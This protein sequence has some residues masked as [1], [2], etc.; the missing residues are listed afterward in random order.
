MCNRSAH[1]GRGRGPAG[2]GRRDL[3][4]AAAVRWSNG[5][6]PMPGRPARTGSVNGVRRVPTAGGGRAPDDDPRPAL[7]GAGPAGRAT[8]LTARFLARHRFTPEQAGVT[9]VAR[10]GRNGATA[11]IGQHAIVFSGVQAKLL[12]SRERTL[13][14]RAC[15][16]ITTGRRGCR[17]GCSHICGLRYPDDRVPLVHRPLVERRRRLNRRGRPIAIVGQPRLAHRFQKKTS[18]AGRRQVRPGHSGRWFVT[19]S[20]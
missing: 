7:H 15:G 13:S 1:G 9:G 18:P 12:R 11:V 14:S 17:G 3:G 19:T 2:L 5:R 20:E 10:G 4:Q 16:N 6:C 8:E